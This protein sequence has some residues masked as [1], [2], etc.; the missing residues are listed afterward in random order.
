MPMEDE[1]IIEIAKHQSGTDIADMFDC[2]PNWAPL[3]TAQLKE[4]VADEVKKPQTAVFAIWSNKELVGI[5]EW[6]ASWDTWSPYAWFVVLPEHRRKGLGTAIGRMLLG[7]CFLEHPGHELA[8]GVSDSNAGA[9]ALLKK[10]GFTD[11]GRMRRV[12]MEAGKY[13]DVR[14]FDILKSEYLAGVKP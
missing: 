11:I 13:H 7:K 1:V 4:K 14:F 3:T 6:S 2:K 12:G 5:G 10:L 8:V 9:V